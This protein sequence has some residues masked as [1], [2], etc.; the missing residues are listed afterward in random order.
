MHGGSG[1][2]GVGSIGYGI[3]HTTEDLIPLVMER[4]PVA[5]TEKVAVVFV[6]VRMLAGC[7]VITTGVELAST[8]IWMPT[9]VDLGKWNPQQNTDTPV[10]QLAPQMGCF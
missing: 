7:F 3:G 1:V 8:V 9:M 10:W 5:P 2:S 6:G 4:D